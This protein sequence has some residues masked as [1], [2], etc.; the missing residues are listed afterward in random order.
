MTSQDIAD[1][2]KQMA[3]GYATYLD[4]DIIDSTNLEGAW[5]FDME[6][7]PPGRWREQRHRDSITIFE[8]VNK[9]LGLTLELHDVPLPLMV[10]KS[11]NR[12]PTPNAPGSR[13]RAGSPTSALRSRHRQA[14]GSGATRFHRRQRRRPV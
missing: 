13:D 11:V 10:V 5:D 3:G 2:L 9:Q 12:K 7:T 4:H 8:A 6:W 14:H 1:T